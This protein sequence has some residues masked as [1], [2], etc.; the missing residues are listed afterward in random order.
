MEIEGNR[1]IEKQF[2]FNNNF[3]NNLFNYNSL[4][5]IILVSLAFSFLF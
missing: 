1:K 4:L 3:N 5:E 2:T